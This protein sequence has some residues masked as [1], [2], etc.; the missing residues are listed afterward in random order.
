[1]YPRTIKPIIAVVGVN[2]LYTSTPDGSTAFD[3]DNMPCWIDHG[4]GSFGLPSVG[5][6]AA[7]RRPS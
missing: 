1:M 4:E 3:Q 2:V 7:S 5:G 6:L